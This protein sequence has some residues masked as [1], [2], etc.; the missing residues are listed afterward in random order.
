MSFVTG[1]ATL[2]SRR[3]M[4]IHERSAFVLVTIQAEGLLVGAK[5]MFLRRAVR[6]MT[7]GA[8]DDA[9][10]QAVMRRLVEVRVN[11]IMAGETQ[12]CLL[13]FEHCAHTGIV[14]FML[15]LSTRVHVVA[16]GA[17]D[18]S[19]EMFAQ[20][21]MAL[22]ARALMAIEAG[23]R[24]FVR[25]FAFHRLDRA[26]GT[27]SLYVFGG[28]TMTAFAR[29]AI[30]PGFCMRRALVRSDF[31]FMAF[32]AFFRVGLGAL[33]RGILGRHVLGCAPTD[34]RAFARRYVGRDRCAGR[35]GPR[36]GGRQ[37]GPCVRNEGSFHTACSQDD[38]GTD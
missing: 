33:E 15:M 3:V 30:L 38:C 9:F 27:A 28:F 17:A 21:T 7:T 29:L 36:D 26:G 14:H 32:H 18:A 16:A 11:R 4:F 34:H 22:F 5:L 13:A 20:L 31:V 2:E 6:I 19:A 35:S 10:L 25:R 12:V 1:D 8:F 24:H 37:T 23:L